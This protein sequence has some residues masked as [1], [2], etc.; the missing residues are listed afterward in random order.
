MKNAYELLEERFGRLGRL[1]GAIEILQ[2]DTQTMM[3]KGSV[4]GRG[5][6]LATL[7]VIAHE[8]LSD[9]QLDD[10]FAKAETL[11]LDGWQSANLYEMR[12]AWRHSNALPADLVVAISKATA[13]CGMAWRTARKED[14][15]A[16]LKPHLEEVFNLVRRQGECKSAALGLT[17]YNALLDEY[18]P[19]VTTDIIDGLFDDLAAFLPDFI[20]EVL[21][22]QQAAP[23]I[24]P[25]KGDFSTERQRT[26]GLK[27]M[28]VLGFDFDRGRLDVSHHPFC[29]GSFGDVRITTRY[30]EESFAESL[31]GVLHETGHALY[32]L[33]RPKPW[34]FQ[35]VGV[36]RSMGTHE[37]QSLLMEMQACRSR[38]FI[39]FVAPQL[40]EAFGSNGEA[41]AEENLY[42]YYTKVERGLIRV[43]ADEV[44]Y[45]AHVIMRYRMERALVSGDLQVADLPGAW[46]DAMKEMIGID[47]PNDRDGCMQDIH[48]IEGIVGYFPTYTLGALIAAQLFEAAKEA[49]GD[50][51]PSISRGDFKPLLGWLRENIHQWGRRYTV[52]ELLNRAT[53]KS[54]DASIFRDHLKARYLPKER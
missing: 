36:S 6:Q 50:I 15:F 31:M 27:M 26:L 16:A 4:E 46:R 54:L 40:R 47:V 3:P 21:A 51:L 52:D 30:S 1:E 5:E 53:G 42:R 10:L 34:A 45:P 33:G 13:A 48:W 22:V 20:D 2:W 12:Q 43:D 24:L 49:N 35:P 19:G 41:W 8:L 18:E 9:P 29:G 11:S 44:T 17:P 23:S 39:T 14:N 38:E 32:E 7:R 37:S 28:G 25:L